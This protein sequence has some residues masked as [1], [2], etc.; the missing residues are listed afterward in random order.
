MFFTGPNLKKIEFP[1]ALD[2]ESARILANK[3][4][5]VFI[6]KFSIALIALVFGIILIFKGVQSESVIEFSYK[7]AQLKLNNA[8]PGVVLSFISL[9]LLLFSRLNIKIK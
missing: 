6:L 5:I 7:G 1:S 2:P 4:F 9:I 3:E 8:L